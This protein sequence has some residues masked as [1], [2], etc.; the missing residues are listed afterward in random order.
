[1]QCI[2]VYIYASVLMSAIC[3]Y[4]FCYMPKYV[5]ISLLHFDMCL[6][7]VS[8]VFAMCLLAGASCIPFSRVAT[9]PCALLL[10]E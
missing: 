10:C 5:D 7:H 3:L 4:T 9:V 2:Y 8:Y 1:M 6:L